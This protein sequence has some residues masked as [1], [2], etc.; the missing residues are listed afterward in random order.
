VEGQTSQ[1]MPV[2]NVSMPLLKEHF[3]EQPPFCLLEIALEHSLEK[4]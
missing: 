2:Y 1:G 4:Q 3:P